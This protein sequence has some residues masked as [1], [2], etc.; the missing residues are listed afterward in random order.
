VQH[1]LA[2]RQANAGPDNLVKHRVAL[3]RDTA[4]Q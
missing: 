1:D 3:I 4:V 2:N